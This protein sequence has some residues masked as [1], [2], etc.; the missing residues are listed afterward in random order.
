MS[1]E[2]E[3][4]A[5]YEALASAT[6]AEYQRL[7]AQLRLLEQAEANAM[8]QYF[9]E[10]RALDPDKAKQAIDRAEAILAK[11]ERKG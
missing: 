2:N 4:N 9:E 8:A 11:Y 1:R 7:L 10:H 5:F 6:E 3:I